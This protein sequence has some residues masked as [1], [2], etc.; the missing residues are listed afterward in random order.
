MHVT[1]NNDLPSYLVARGGQALDLSSD[2]GSDARGQGERDSVGTG[3]GDP[4]GNILDVHVA[5]LEGAHSTGAGDPGHVDI[6]GED[7]LAG[8]GVDLLDGG[9]PGNCRIKNTVNSR[10]NLT[11]QLSISIEI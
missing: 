10:D 11:I 8:H 3:D 2:T 9:E 6:E 5:K 1:N 7:G 4:G